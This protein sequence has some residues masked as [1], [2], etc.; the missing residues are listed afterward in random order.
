MGQKEVNL[1]SRKHDTTRE[2]L[3]VDLS[4]ETLFAMLWR[5]YKKTMTSMQRARHTGFVSIDC[6]HNLSKAQELW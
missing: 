1:D 2:A 6:N 5:F 3:S 4:R